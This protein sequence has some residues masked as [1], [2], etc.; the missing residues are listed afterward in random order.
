[1]GVRICV[2]WSGQE[3]ERHGPPPFRIETV[4]DMYVYIYIYMNVY[5]HSIDIFAFLIGVKPAFLLMHIIVSID[6]SD[7]PQRLK[8][9]SSN[10]M[11]EDVS[12]IMKLL[13]RRVLN[14]P[15]SIL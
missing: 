6:C 12:E 11:M 2:Y 4:W 5:I 10:S 3:G 13:I 7:T 15:T 9:M 1:M 8:R 14:L